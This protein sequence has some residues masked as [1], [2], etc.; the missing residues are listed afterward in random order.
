VFDAVIMGAGVAGLHAAYRLQQGGASVA[1]L[2]ARPRVGGRLA[3]FDVAGVALDLGATWVWPGE[4]RVLGLIDEL[5]LSTFAHFDAGVGLYD[6]PGGPQR[7]PPGSM[8]GPSRRITGGSAALTEALRDRLE[9]GTVRTGTPVRRVT[10]DDEGLRVEAGGD[11]V[12]GRHVLLALPPALAVASIGF[13]PALPD[14]VAQIAAGTPVWMGGVVKTVVAYDRPFW[15]EAGLSGAAFSARGPLQEIHDL[16]GADDTPGALFGFTG[17]TDPGQAAPE[18]DA[19]LD[20]LVRLFGAAAAQPLDFQ[21]KDWSRE[22]ETSPP[23]AVTLTRYER[24]GDPRLTRAHLNGRLHFCSC[25][26][27]PGHGHIE[28]ALAASARAVAAIA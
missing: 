8:G 2:E 28:G 23:G 26:A 18:R 11:V 20:Q 9:P 4:P 13:D 27:N 7:M 5:G 10:A 19:V 16:S 22:P 24:F 14:D 12:R 6:G 15:R 17:L 1:V 25:E 21:Q 3:S